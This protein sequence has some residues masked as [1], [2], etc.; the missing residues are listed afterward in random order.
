MTNCSIIYWRFFF[1]FVWVLIRLSDCQPWTELGVIVHQWLRRT[2]WQP[3]SFIRRHLS[4]LCWLK[5]WACHQSCVHMDTC[6]SS[7]KSNDSKQRDKT[8]HLD[9]RSWVCM[10]IVNIHMR[11]RN[12]MRALMYA[13]HVLVWITH[14][15]TYGWMQGLGSLGNTFI[16]TTTP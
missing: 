14:T 13:M 15:H 9:T 16:E 11:P 7:H 12:W 10:Q 3:S 6:Q 8:E 5:L 2:L 4:G 1:F